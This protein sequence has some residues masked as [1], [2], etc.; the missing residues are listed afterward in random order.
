MNPNVFYFSEAADDLTGAISLVIFLAFIGICCAFGE[1]TKREP[2]W[3]F[4]V[5][6]IVLLLAAVA[7]LFSPRGNTLL[8]MVLAGENPEEI[9]HMIEDILSRERALWGG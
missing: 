7:L 4:K 5:C 8:R 9:P 6:T 1:L 3:V 2:K